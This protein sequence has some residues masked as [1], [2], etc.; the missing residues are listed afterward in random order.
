MEQQ[1]KDLVKQLKVVYAC[2]WLIAILMVIAGEMNGAWV[3]GLADD[4][5]LIYMLETLIILLTAICVPVSLKLYSWVLTKKIDMMSITEA[6]KAY[7]RISHIRLFLLAIPVYAGIAIYYL[8]MSSS[9]VLCALIAL[10]ASL[11]CLPGEKRLRSE[12][13][14]QKAEE[15]EGIYG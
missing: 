1:I 3:G 14:I 8:M 11:F 4:V 5:Q 15:E 12:L 10:T 2:F 7:G 9:A 6:L 13:R